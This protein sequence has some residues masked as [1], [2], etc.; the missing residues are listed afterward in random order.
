MAAAH[1][2]LQQHSTANSRSVLLPAFSLSLDA[3]VTISDFKQYLAEKTEEI[4]SLQQRVV[5]CL[6]R[7][8][9]VSHDK[10]LPE[11]AA[12]YTELKAVTWEVA[13]FS[14]VADRRLLA[15]FS[16]VLQFLSPLTAEFVLA[17]FLRAADDM[18]KL[19]LNLL[20]SFT[21]ETRYSLTDA[22]V[23]EQ[24]GNDNSAKAEKLGSICSLAGQLDDILRVSMMHLATWAVANQTSFVTTAASYLVELGKEP[25]DQLLE[26]QTRVYSYTAAAQSQR[27]A[28]QQQANQLA[29]PQGLLSTDPLALFSSITTSW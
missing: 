14:K 5:D 6:Q 13:R 25:A 22:L 2:C 1:R 8:R 29:D 10:P 28:E 19:R 12:L 9:P 26:A 21:A 23:A 17:P 3:C 20:Q 27:R 11:L 7:Y 15:L 4:V 24:Q 16:M 18:Q